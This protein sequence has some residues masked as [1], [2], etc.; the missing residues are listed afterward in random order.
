[1]NPRPC[2]MEMVIHLGRIL[3]SEMANH[4]NYRPLCKWR[5]MTLEQIGRDSRGRTRA[6]IKSSNGKSRRFVQEKNMFS[7]SYVRFTVG[8]LFL[9]KDR[10]TVELGHLDFLHP[11]KCITSRK[12]AFTDACHTCT[13]T[14]LNWIQ[15]WVTRKLICAPN[16]RFS[17]VS[18]D[19]LDIFGSFSNRRIC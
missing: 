11:F 3:W 14:P 4:H 18:L 16:S 8:E 15:R 17:A 6:S 5:G 19:I 12:E 2:G 9:L 13:R 7:T 10:P 1:M